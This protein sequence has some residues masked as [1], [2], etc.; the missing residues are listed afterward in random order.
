MT[1]DS[2]TSLFDLKK[3]ERKKALNALF[4]QQKQTPEAEKLSELIKKTPPHKCK[5]IFQNEYDSDAYEVIGLANLLTKDQFAQLPDIDAMTVYYMVQ[6]MNEADRYN[7][8]WMLKLQQ[9]RPSL[10]KEYQS[11]EQWKPYIAEFDRLIELGKAPSC[12]R[13]TIGKMIE[14]ENIK[15]SNRGDEL[16]CVKKSK[17]GTTKSKPN[18]GTLSRQLVP[19]PK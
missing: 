4:P 11:E 5:K 6:R 7:S 19:N 2:D 16:I 15:R 9:R 17:D 18:R 12:A 13:N 1:E 14:A 10:V 3:N 8:H